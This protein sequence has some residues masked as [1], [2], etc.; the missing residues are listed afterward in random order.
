MW[1]KYV[2]IIRTNC[3]AIVRQPDALLRDYSVCARA[4]LYLL[5]FSAYSSRLY[6]CRLYTLK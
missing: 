5:T 1:W 3:I 6:S 4:F 2:L